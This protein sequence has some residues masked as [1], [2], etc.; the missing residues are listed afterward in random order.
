MA[1]DPDAD[2]VGAAVKNN[3]GE[4]VLLNGNQTALMFVY[5]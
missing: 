4:W 2:R 1:S 3:E 5:Y